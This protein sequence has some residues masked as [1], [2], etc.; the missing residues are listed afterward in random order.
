MLKLQTPVEFAESDIKFSFGDYI[1][2]LGSCFTDNIGK[3]MKDMGFNVCVNP[4]GTLYN[5][6]SICNSI[7]RLESAVPFS[8]DECVR[9]GAGSQ[10]FCSFSHHTAAGGSFGF[11]P[12]DIGGHHHSRHS[13][14]VQVQCYRGNRFQLSET[15]REGIYARETVRQYLLN[16]AEFIGREVSG[17]AFHLHCQ[18]DTSFERRGARKPAQQEHPADGDGARGAGPSGAMRIFPGL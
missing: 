18:S 2:L 8:E 3:I 9:M 1:M 17:Q 6:V 11:F 5:P 13:M 16:A 4:F 14:D 12:Q 10:L 7:R 15:R